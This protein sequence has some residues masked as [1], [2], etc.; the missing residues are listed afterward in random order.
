VREHVTQ[1]ILSLHCPSHLVSLSSVQ[2]LFA[3][4]LRSNLVL[5]FVTVLED[6][7]A[8]PAGDPTMAEGRV[9]YG[10]KTSRNSRRKRKSLLL[11]YLFKAFLFYPCRTFRRWELY[12]KVVPLSPPFVQ[13]IV[14]TVFYGRSPPRS[15]LI[16]MALRP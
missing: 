10:M 15:D 2:P 9:L 6:P 16:L 13:S 1:F 3:G 14:N 7:S 11:F 4:C 8:P 12:T 5:A